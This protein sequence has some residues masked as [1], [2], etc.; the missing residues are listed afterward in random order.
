MRVRTAGAPSR[1][2]GPP[3]PDPIAL[4]QQRRPVAGRSDAVRRFSARAGPVPAPTLDLRPVPGVR[5]SAAASLALVLLAIAPACGRDR[6][7][8][9]YNVLLLSLD[10]VRQDA[11]GCYGRRPR[12]APVI[13][14]SPVLD[15]LAGDG[16]RMVDAYAPSS[17]TLPSHL[18]LMTGQPPLV[19]GVETEVGTLDPSLP[20]MA[21]VLKRH[22][23]RT[24]G[25]YSA[26]YLEPHWGFARGFDEY[27]AAYA[28]EL[29]SVSEEAATIRADVERAAGARDWKAYDDL[30][31]RE[32][33]IVANL[34]RRSE[35]AVS[36]DA[37]T[38]AVVSRLEELAHDAA[39]W[40]VFAHFFDAHCDYVPPPP[41]DTRFDPDYQGSATGEGCLGGAWV[42]R[43]DPDHPGAFVRAIA[44]R[45]LEHVIALYEGEI[46]WVD[47]HVGT[48]LRSLD[49]LG[50]ARK[51][52]VIVV[53]DHGEEFFEHADIGHRRTLYEEVVRVPMLLRL[54]SVLPAG[55][56]VRGPVSLTDVLS[57]VLD[58]L[59]LPP[60]PAPAGRSFLP[61]I[62]GD[63]DGRRRSVFERL[64]MM[65][66][67]DV[68][69]DSTQ[70]VTLRQVMVQDVFQQGSIKVRRSRSWPQF[71]ADVSPDM[72]AAFQREAAAQY[73]REQVEW[74]DLARSPDEPADAYSAEFTGASAQAALA[75]FGR[76]YGALVPLRRRHEAPVPENV[77]ARL[78]SLGY[79]DTRSGPEFPEPDVV[80][81]PPRA[82]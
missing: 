76:E 18:S 60:V 20:T 27:R 37:V 6:R 41:Y 73:G 38:A 62:R 32:V 72:K 1:P 69:V 39:P 81:P 24:F 2:R 59:G 26:P 29:V 17:W 30:K 5:R 45:D 11:L 47:A 9:P 49:T 15:Q 43:P 3:A 75:A 34:N 79:V 54:P 71:P 44:D 42:G 8:A 4:F 19:H 67:G 10:T 55:A 48:I 57:T 63:E 21:E 70:H 13:S 56:A 33:K 64:V 58:I 65:F 78:E 50:L 68:E 31:R 80:L 51:T 23:Y 66:A 77:R 36:S 52:L 82:G 46:A 16:V 28:P 40:F 12:H 7:G 14:P 74:I 35:T 53:S 25:V 61:L 22:G